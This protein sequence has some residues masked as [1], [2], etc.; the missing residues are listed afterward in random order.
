MIHFAIHPEMNPIIRY[1]MMFNIDQFEPVMGTQ[2]TVG[3]AVLGRYS[4]SICFRL[5]C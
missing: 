5:L 2:V 3:S 1:Q 4:S